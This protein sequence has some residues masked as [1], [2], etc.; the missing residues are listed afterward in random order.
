M[1][2]LQI[3][4]HQELA[5]GGLL[6]IVISLSWNAF[7]QVLKDP[8]YFWNLFNKGYN[9]RF[10]VLKP[11]R[12]DS[13]SEVTWRLVKLHSVVEHWENRC[14]NLW[15]WNN[16]SHIVS[17]A[18]QSKKRWPLQ[19]CC[20]AVHW[21]KNNVSAGLAH[22]NSSSTNFITHKH[23][24]FETCSFF[25]HVWRNM[26]WERVGAA[27]LCFS[28]SRMY[29]DLESAWTWFAEGSAD[30]TGLIYSQPHYR[31]LA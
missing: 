16:P 12:H 6:V 23:L 18:R 5:N 17:T 31:M 9:Y 7:F 8:R 4:G 11:W 15:I 10:S 27:H 2:W 28:Q 29:S 19:A 20:I 3:I 21:G 25:C 24:S 22:T 13:T 26:E 14:I 30:V 1:T